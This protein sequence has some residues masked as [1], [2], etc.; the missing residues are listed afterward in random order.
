MTVIQG[1]RLSP[2]LALLV[3]AAVFGLSIPAAHADYL[4][5]Q[6]ADHLS[7]LPILPGPQPVLTG[8]RAE[9]SRSFLGFAPYHS[10]AVVD[11]PTVP[12]RPPTQ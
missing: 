5:D 10:V 12:A 7:T 4:V 1:F 3:G 6:V 8:S 9:Q 11:E 2:V